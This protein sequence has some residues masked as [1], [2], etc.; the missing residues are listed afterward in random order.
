MVSRRDV[1]IILPAYNEGQAIGKVIDEIRSLPMECEILAG[2]NASSDDTGKVIWEKG[3]RSIYVTEKGK[4]N[5]IRALIKHVDTPYTI[6]VNADY[7][8]PL[9]YATTIYNLLS[10]TGADVVMGFRSIKEKGSM[11]FTNSFGNWCLSLL[12]SVLYGKR[13]Y[14]VC[15]GLVGFRTDRLKTFSITSEGFT[16]EAD[17]FI[18]SMRSGCR[19]EQIPIA[20]RKRLDGSEAKLKFVDGLRIGW[21][22]LK[23]RFG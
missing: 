7:T 8:Y 17:L 14:D 15:T 12:A 10:R 13:V 11:S 3:L 21:F 6:M 22:L 20:Y 19:I 5:V 4:G 2:D 16:L 9:E 1:T 18:N 23:R